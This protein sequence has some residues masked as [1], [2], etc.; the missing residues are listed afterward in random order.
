MGKMFTRVKS[1]YLTARA[2]VEE[3][4]RVAHTAIIV[5]LA[6]A[7]I[8]RWANLVGLRERERRRALASAGLLEAIDTDLKAT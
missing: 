5:R 6:V 7:V 2:V 1:S 3:H 8:G 4:E